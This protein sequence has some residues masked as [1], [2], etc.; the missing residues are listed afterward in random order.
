MQVWD[1]DSS[2]HLKSLDIMVGL[3]V[4]GEL[5]GRGAVTV[6]KGSVH[7]V[8]EE[9]VIEDV[10][11]LLDGLVRV[12]RQNLAFDYCLRTLLCC[13][14]KVLVHFE[15]GAFF[16]DSHQVGI[17]V[18]GAYNLELF[19]PLTDLFWV[20]AMQRNCCLADTLKV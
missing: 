1:I 11:V 3:R 5:L 13:I 6:A 2:E 9:D 17:A 18:K 20:K 10:D 12:K 4:A 7:G 16:L 8:R 19:I 15:R 14:Q